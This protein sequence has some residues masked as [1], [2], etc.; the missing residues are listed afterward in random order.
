MKHIVEFPMEN[1]D[2]LLVE[3]DDPMASGATL[4]GGHG[5]EMLERAQMTYEQAVDKIKPAAESIVRRIRDIPEPPD[6]IGVEFGIKLN[7]NIG[8][9][10]AS[11]SVEAQF[12]LKLTWNREVLAEM[13]EQDN[14][15]SQPEPPTPEER[16]VGASVRAGADAVAG[17]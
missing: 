6:V 16:V 4:R 14:L 8:A 12:T 1:G 15:E 13:R 9:I 10:L 11:S 5:S 17:N 3:V 2:V 7:A